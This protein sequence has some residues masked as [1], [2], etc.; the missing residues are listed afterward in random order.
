MLIKDPDSAAFDPK[1]MPNYRVTAVYG[2]NRIEVQDEKGNKSVRRAAHVKLCEPVDKVIH[3]LPPQAVYEQYGRRSKLLI[4]PKDVPEIPL[5]IFEPS[6][7]MREKVDESD[8]SQNRTVT[9]VTVN[10]ITHQTEV[11]QEG[12][13]SRPTSRDSSDDRQERQLNFVTKDLFQMDSDSSDESRN[14]VN[15][16]PL[17]KSSVEIRLQGMRTEV[18]QEVTCRLGET[19]CSGQQSYDRRVEMSTRDNYL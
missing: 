1:Y 7:D 19:M 9:D 13:N 5:Q 18:P 2:R 3:Q 16:V 8:E 11:M 6:Q 15:F 10:E 17:Y 14:R 4:H 12:T